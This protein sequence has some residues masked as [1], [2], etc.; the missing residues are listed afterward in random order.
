MEDEKRP[1][2][3]FANFIQFIGIRAFDQWAERN[4]S[5]GRA[6]TALQN[7]SSYWRGLSQA[8][9]ERFFGQVI[10]AA[11]TAAAAAVPVVAAGIVKLKERKA[12]RRESGKRRSETTEVKVETVSGAD[13]PKRRSATIRTT[14]SPA[15]R[16][17]APKSKP[18][19][20]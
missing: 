3:E 6:T 11:Q 1:P 19:R 16:T 2:A 7:L 13:K 10:A 17:R 12:A 18:E 8:E 5:E 9:K 4:R 14:A 15:R 20:D